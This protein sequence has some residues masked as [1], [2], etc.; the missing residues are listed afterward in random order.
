MYVWL[1][2]PKWQG[3]RSR[4]AAAATTNCQSTAHRA[5]ARTAASQNTCSTPCNL[6]AHQ[7][8]RSPGLHVPSSCRR[9]SVRRSTSWTGAQTCHT[10]GTA[11]S[12]CPCVPCHTCHSAGHTALWHD[13]LCRR[14]RTRGSCS[15]PPHAPCHHTYSRW[16][17][18]QAM[19][20][21]CCC[22]QQPPPAAAPAAGGE[23]EKTAAAA[24]LAA[25]VVR[26]VGVL[27]AVL[28]G[29]C[30]CCCSHCAHPHLLQQR[31][32]R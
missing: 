10:A 23:Q 19:S 6:T 22:G 14:W 9:R 4:A 31:Q 28:A 32:Q 20:T 12:P 26:V 27:P 29:H 16:A 3:S 25:A 2:S 17:A 5:L 18:W 30:Y 24:G 21:A 8:A 7:M 1:C 13:P 15:W 11:C